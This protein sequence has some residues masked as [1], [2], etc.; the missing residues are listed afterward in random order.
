MTLTMRTLPIAIVFLATGLLVLPLAACQ[1]SGSGEDEKRPPV[2]SELHRVF[3]KH[4]QGLEELSIELVKSDYP[5]VALW[6]NDSVR[7]PNLDSEEHEWVEVEEPNEWKALFQKAGVDTASNYRGKISLHNRFEAAGT[8]DKTIYDYVF[9]KSDEFEELKCI[10]RYSETEC[11]SCSEQLDDRW[12]LRLMWYPSDWIAGF[13]EIE[14][15]DAE[16]ENELV[17]TM[18]LKMSACMDRF[19]EEQ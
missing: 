5:S 15:G 3:F 10:P 9:V 13:E 11:G 19:F 2:S 8:F 18:Q 4:Q 7:A 6:G 16:Q 1:R 14:E 17:K 12:S